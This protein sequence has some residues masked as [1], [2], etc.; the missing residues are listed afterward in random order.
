MSAYGRYYK[1]KAEQQK[2]QFE[3]PKRVKKFCWKLG[4]DVEFT[5]GKCPQEGCLDRHSKG[6]MESAGLVV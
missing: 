2:R 3:E 5:D 6:C 1:A 4:T